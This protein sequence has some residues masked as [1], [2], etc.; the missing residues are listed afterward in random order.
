VKAVTAALPSNARAGHAF[1]RSMQTHIA[2]LSKPSVEMAAALVAV[3]YGLPQVLSN[4]MLAELSQRA[5]LSHVSPLASATMK[6]GLR[7]S[8]MHIGVEL[9]DSTADFALIHVLGRDAALEEARQFLA[10]LVQNLECL[11]LVQD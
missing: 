11:A 1:L 10:L 7:S 2:L 5:D 8:M 6:I 4:W 9:E 3:Q